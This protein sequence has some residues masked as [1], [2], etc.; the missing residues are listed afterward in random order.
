MLVHPFRAGIGALGHIE[1]MCEHVMRPGVEA[2]ERQRLVSEIFGPPVIAA[3]LES[4]RSIAST[5]WIARQ[6]T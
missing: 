1:Y 5:A 2:V 3:L 6:I 4:E